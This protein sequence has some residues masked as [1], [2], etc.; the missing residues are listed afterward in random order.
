ML[1]LMQSSS[2]VITANPSCIAALHSGMDG[3][4]QAGE[5][6]ADVHSV[7]PKP[8][9]SSSILIDLSIINNYHKRRISTHLGLKFRPMMVGDCDVVR[10]IH[11]YC[12]PVHYSEVIIFLASIWGHAPQPLGVGMYCHVTLVRLII[13]LFTLLGEHG[14]DRNPR[15]CTGCI[16]TPMLCFYTWGWGKNHNP[17]IQFKHEGWFEFIPTTLDTNIV[18]FQLLQRF[19]NNACRC[20][21]LLVLVVLLL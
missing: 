15:H 21:C 20:L 18:P 14:V 19:Y 8:P 16:Y 3:I 13:N 4:F 1:K 2:S 17:F 9:S 6:Y 7:P 5:K 11:E 12:L 10:T